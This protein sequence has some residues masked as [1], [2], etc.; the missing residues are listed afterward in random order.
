MPDFRAITA[1]GADAPRNFCNGPLSLVENADLALASL[2]LRRGVGQPVPFD[3]TLP[4]PGRW[5]RKGSVSAFWTGPDQ[6]MIEA[7]ERAESDFARELAAACPGCSVTEQTDGFVA[8][9]IRAD[10]GERPI[11]A[12]M[13]KLVNLDATRF[14][15][16]SATRVG[17][18]HMS[19]FAIRR[20]PAHLAIVGMRSAAETLW[21][22]LETAISRLAEIHA[23]EIL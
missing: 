6:W 4:G 8:F 5:F 14:A 23:R 22:G 2:A 12:L 7:E 17:L 11:L 15:G 18:E 20:A 13:S 9:E 10:S 1:L 21:H 19:V 16:G 3:I